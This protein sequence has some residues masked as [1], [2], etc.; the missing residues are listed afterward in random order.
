MIPYLD[1]KALNELYKDAIFESFK[2]TFESAWYILGKE[3]K[4]FE[5]EF[6]DF[7]GTQH[8]V[9]VA[10]GLD[11][12][13]LI[14]TAYKEM[15]KLKSGDE[16]IVPANTYIASILAVLHA[17]LKP[18]FVEPNAESYNL[19][20]QNIEKHIG[21]KTK[22]I[23]VV[24]LYGQLAD[25]PALKTISKKNSLLLIED[26]AQAHGAIFQNT[27]AGAWGEASGFSFY[28]GKNLGALGDAGAVTTSDAELASVVRTL[29]NYGSQEK[30]VNK[31]KGTNSRLDEVQAAILRV[32]LKGLDT[33]T[34][35]RQE[36]S[37]RYR[38]DIK[39]KLVKLP[40]VQNEEAHVW[41]IFAVQVDDRNMFKKHLEENGVQTLIHYPIAPHKQEALR[42]YSHLKLPIT[43]SI[44]E[45]VLSLPLYSTLSEKQISQVIASVNSY[46]A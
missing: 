1:L 45:R 37:R 33:E 6:S 4:A 21:P 38:Q 25:M 22:A 44:H 12:L 28:P 29:A 39:N 43:E 31:Y 27:K 19:C 20:P 14:L 13:T 34:K 16:V 36:I 8:C 41:H 26:S 18:V 35:K 3:V 7:C 23:L 11:A 30:Y 15:G 24:H 42:E 2:K 17:D 32:K 46:G 9:G 40:H 10:N 5:K